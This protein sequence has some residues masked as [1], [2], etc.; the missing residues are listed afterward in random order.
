[1]IY[2]YHFVKNGVFFEA[3][4]DGRVG[5]IRKAESRLQSRTLLRIDLTEV[6]WAEA[7]WVM[8]KKHK[9]V[10]GDKVIAGVE[11][12]VEPTVFGPHSEQGSSPDTLP[13]APLPVKSI[14]T[15]EDEIQSEPELK[16]RKRKPW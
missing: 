5:I 1:M 11:V 3:G 4:E 14:K 2:P 10:N 16:R 7:I 13:D 6:E 15:E 12:K 9:E 8:N